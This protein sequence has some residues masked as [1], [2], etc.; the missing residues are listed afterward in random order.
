MKPEEAL[1]Q[2]IWNI[3]H[4][5]TPHNISL[6]LFEKSASEIDINEM[7]S[8]ISQD[9]TVSALALKTANSVH[10]SRGVEIK[11]I[12]GA[13]VHLGIDNIKKLLFAVEMLGIFRGQCVSEKFSEIDFWRHTLAGAILASKYAAYRKSCDPDVAYAAAL[14]RDIG[15]LAVRQFFPAEFDQMLLIQETEILSFKIL[16]KMFFGISYRDLSSTIGLSWR[17][18]RTIVE[19]IMEAANLHEQSDEIQAIRE[20]IAF[21]DAFLYATHYYIWDK[22]D[23]PADFDFQ[24]VPTERMHEESSKMVDSIIREFW[25]R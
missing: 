9:A 3:E 4:I 6:K 12:K 21:T 13:V 1:Q 8:M 10:F 23:I 20:A 17:L 2:I 22:Y 18:P 7:V 11:T 25:I 5:G 15:M 14:L 19:S 24:N 16:T